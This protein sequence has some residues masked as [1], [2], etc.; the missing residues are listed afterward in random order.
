MFTNS[1]HYESNINAVI[2]FYEARQ[3]GLFKYLPE[4]IR[5]LF[6]D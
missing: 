4:N 1:L 2:I 5:I 3:N 6:V